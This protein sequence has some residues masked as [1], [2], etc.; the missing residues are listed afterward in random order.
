MYMV[1]RNHLL[2]LRVS[3]D[4]LAQLKAISDANGEPMAVTVRRWIRASYRDRFGEEDCRAPR[5]K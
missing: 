2:N 3:D 1:E 5:A 4:E